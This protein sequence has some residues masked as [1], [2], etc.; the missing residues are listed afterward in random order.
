[1]IR[2]AMSDPRT[3]DPQTSDSGSSLRLGDDLAIRDLLAR[4][5]DAIHRRAPDDWAATWAPDAT[6]TLPD[7]TDSDSALVMEGRDDIVAGWIAAMEG[8]PFVAHI[9]HSGVINW[10]GAESASGR[11]YVTEIVEAEDGSRFH[12]YGVYNDRYVRM[13]GRWLFRERVFSLLYM[14]DAPWN[15]DTFR[16][17][18]EVGLS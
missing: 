10:Q 2:S 7:I 16:H 8:Y 12:F 3:S 13:D 11:W 6:W 15:G 18:Q 4:Y 9:L 1:M 14:G 17:P 5:V